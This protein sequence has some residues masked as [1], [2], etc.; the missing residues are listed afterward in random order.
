MKTPSKSIVI[1]AGGSGGHLFP[2]QTLALQLQSAYPFY[3]I[4]FIGKG[5]DTSRFFQRERFAYASVESS[6]ISHK[7]LFRGFFLLCKGVIQALSL[8]K[9][10]KPSVVVG[11]GSFHS[12]PVLAAAVLR[13]I[14]IVLFES[15]AIPGRVNRIFSR[16]ATLSCIQ[17]PMAQK[18]LKGQC[19][20]VSMPTW[21]G[22]EKKEVTEEEALA[23]FSL[24]KGRVTFL[25]FG[26]SQ[27]ARFINTVFIDA[28]HKVHKQHTALQVIHLTGDKTS[29]EEIQNE[30]DKLGVV[31]CVKHFEP[32]MAFAWKI[33]DVAI[34]R[35]GAAT[36]SEL[37]HFEVPSILIPYPYAAEQH[38][39]KNALFLESL[40]GAFCL[41][42]KQVSTDNLLSLIEPFLIRSSAIWQTMKKAL[43]EFKEKKSKVLLC[44]LVHQCIEDR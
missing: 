31:A 12:F 13:K 40:G 25:V 36:L 11:F 29:Q 6:S 4:V 38:Q 15:N 1:A 19:Q 22:I 24:H 9:K 5:L 3:D 44:D 35:A 8:L 41:E 43:Q 10:Y 32:N 28:L 18:G 39:L 17:F 37:I 26:G 2:A 7:N 21:E 14:P 16:F 34:C 33:A 23:Y 42:E 20:E 27:G 30:Y